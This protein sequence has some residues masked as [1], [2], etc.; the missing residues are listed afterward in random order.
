MLL[1]RFEGLLNDFL[2]ECLFKFEK[3]VKHLKAFD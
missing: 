1:V 3:N 2:E